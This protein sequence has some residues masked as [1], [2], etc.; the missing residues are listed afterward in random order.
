MTIHGVKYSMDLINAFLLLYAAFYKFY[1]TNNFFLCEMGPQ[2][3]HLSFIDFSF[4][5]AYQSLLF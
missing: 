4:N 5:P 2:R 1:P 3:F